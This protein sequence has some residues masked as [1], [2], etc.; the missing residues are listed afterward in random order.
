M[1][2]VWVRSREFQWTQAPTDDKHRSAHVT[3]IAF[4]NL[5]T[6]YQAIFLWH[7]VFERSH[8][9]NFG[10][11]LTSYMFTFTWPIHYDCRW[12]NNYCITAMNEPACAEALGCH[13]AR[14]LD[15]TLDLDSPCPF[16]A[17]TRVVPSPVLWRIPSLPDVVSCPCPRAYTDTVWRRIGNKAAAMYQN[18]AVKCY[19]VCVLTQLM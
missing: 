6:S 9:I 18:S 2:P 1:L 7:L 19:N 13:N 14:D 4:P 15:S 5:Q 11:H 8:V 17:W 16:L 12:V 10:S 3:P